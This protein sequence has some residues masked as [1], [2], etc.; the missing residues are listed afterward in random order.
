[1]QRLV[2][3]AMINDELI[4]FDFMVGDIVK[5]K[6]SGPKGVITQVDNPFVYIDWID[7]EVKKRRG[8]RWMVSGVEYAKEM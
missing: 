6:G 5:D 7:E 2:Q 4:T 3:R 8:S 1:M